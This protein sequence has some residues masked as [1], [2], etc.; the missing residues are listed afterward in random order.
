MHT[1]VCVYMHDRERVEVER[2]KYHPSE[3]AGKA[4]SRDWEI[5][6]ETDRAED[7]KG[8]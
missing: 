6:E 1:R 4:Q 3:K 8:M 5:M 2:E 7:W